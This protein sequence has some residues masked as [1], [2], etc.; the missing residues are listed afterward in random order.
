[1]CIR[2]YNKITCSLYHY[3][4]THEMY[5]NKK[6]LSSGIKIPVGYLGLVKSSYI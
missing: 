6:R 2:L 1:M 4:F 5:V 3:K